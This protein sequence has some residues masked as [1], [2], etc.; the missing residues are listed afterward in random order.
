[1]VSRTLYGEGQVIFVGLNL[2][3]HEAVNDDPLAIRIL[4]SV[5]GIPAK[6]PS[7]DKT[8]A[9]EN[10]EASEDGWRFNITLPS[11]QWVLLPMGMHGG[12]SV[13]VGGE[14]V[15]IV[16]VESLILA[17]LPGGTSSVH[18]KSEQ[19]GIYAIG[20]ATTVIGVLATLY[21]LTSG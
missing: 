13:E 9:M 3:F 17:K 5:L 11:E 10:Y 6:R 20:R 19:T 18:I 15:D 4:E 2:M 21:N 16:G 8:I 14:K 1:M 12:T 7:G